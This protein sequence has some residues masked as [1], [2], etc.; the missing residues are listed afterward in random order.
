M[1]TSPLKPLPCSPKICVLHIAVTD[2][3]TLDW[4]KQQIREATPWNDKPRFLIHDNDGIFGQYRNRR[5]G[6]PRC[7]LDAWLSEA[8]GIKGIPIP[9]GAPNAAAHVERFYAESPNML[10]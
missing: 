1:R 6:Q 3:P 8:M 10:R 7:A 2:S 5:R 9:Y 4:V